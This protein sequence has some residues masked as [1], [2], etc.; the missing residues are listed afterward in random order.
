MRMLSSVFEI[1]KIIIKWGSQFCE[2]S[3]CSQSWVALYQSRNVLCRLSLSLSSTVP[4]ANCVCS[5]SDFSFTVWR[6]ADGVAAVWVIF[7][8]FFFNLFLRVI[9]LLVQSILGFVFIIIIIVLLFTF[10]IISRVRVVCWLLKDIPS[11][12]KSTRVCLFSSMAWLSFCW[13]VSS[14]ANYIFYR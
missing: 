6:P 5:W 11:W 1:T 12:C 3:T 10:L 14:V 4:V 8:I 2:M 9:F 13:L 7:V